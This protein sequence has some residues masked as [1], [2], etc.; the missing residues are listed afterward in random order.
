[1]HYLSD[2]GVSIEP[3]Y[4][5]PVIPTVLINGSDGIGTGWS[6]AVPNYDPREIINNIRKLINGEEVDPMHPAYT[7]YNGTIEYVGEQKYD[8]KGRIER[9]D[10]TTLVITELPVKMSI[11]SM[12]E[13]LDKQ[14]NETAKGADG[15]DIKDFTENHTDA[16]VHFTIT[17]TK[18]KIDEWEKEKGGLY[19]KFGLISSLSTSNMNLYD[20]NGR[21]I[22]YCSPEKILKTFFDQRLEFYVKRKA[23]LVKKLRRERLILSNKARFVE[24]VC[25]GDLVV[26]NRKKVD[27]LDELQQR[28]YDLFDAK[29]ASV[30]ASEDDVD[31]SEEEDDLSVAKLSKGYEYLLGM[32]IWNLTFE[33][34][35]EI[36]AQLEE[37]TGELNELEAT[38]PSNLWERDLS[39]I[40]EALTERDEEI[41]KA[42]EDEQEAKKKTTKRNASK[43]KKTKVATAAAKR[44]PA[45]KVSVLD[46]DE[47]SDDDFVDDMSVVVLPKKAVSQRKPV[48]TKA[49][50]APAAVS[51]PAPKIDLTATAPK[52]PM[53]E[54][55]AF[56]GDDDDDDHMNLDLMSRL[57]AKKQ[58][59]SKAE[60]IDQDR[61]D[62]SSS[63]SSSKRPSPKSSSDPTSKKAKKCTSAAINKKAAPAKK[64]ARKKKKS[65]DDSD[66]EDFE[67]FGGNDLDSDDGIPPPPQRSGRARRGATKTTNYA[68]MFDGDSSIEEEDS[69][70]DF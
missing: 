60:K 23:L 6:S 21:I 17:A 15:P 54:E 69:D 55:K 9:V 20:V 46:S 65:F 1:L 61:D 2:D 3:E 8:V 24:E 32:K 26:S 34:V 56:G 68:A 63:G 50:A 19:K 45:K 27:L 16:T 7:G 36:R 11:Q 43:A 12:K 47:D 44:K 59:P 4:F 58:N 13:R 39:A 35:E 28:K 67:D 29:D 30:S 42:A 64:A 52:I 41:A 33:K 5:M 70:D 51:K 66:E 62:V 31:E 53:A 14:M 57:L 40:E 18:E 49:T 25:K 22:K 37:R 38:S 48:V 10:D